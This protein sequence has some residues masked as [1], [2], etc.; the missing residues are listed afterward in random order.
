MKKV[1]ASLCALLALLLFTTRTRMTSQKPEAAT[2]LQV[3]NVPA[4]TDPKPKSVPSHI[5]VVSDQ[6]DGSIIILDKGATFQVV[7]PSSNR[8]VAV[9]EAQ[10]EVQL[11]EK[12]QR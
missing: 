8:V 6:N 4:K 3:S 9:T 2:I 11:R 10:L 5:A 1:I 12:Q 7:S